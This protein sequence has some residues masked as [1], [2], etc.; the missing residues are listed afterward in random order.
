VTTSQTARV[1]NIEKI[2]ITDALDGDDVDLSLFGATGL[3]L[4][5]TDNTAEVTYSAGTGT[6]ELGTTDQEESTF[7]V[8]GNLA[9]SSDVLNITMGSSS[10]AGTGYGLLNVNNF[11]TVNVQFLVGALSAGEAN[12]GITMSPSI[13]STVNVTGSFGSAMGVIT[14]STINASALSLTGV[15]ATGVTLTAGIGSYVTGSMGVDALTGSTSADRLVGG[16][17]ADTLTTAGGSDTLEPG[18]GRD[19]MVMSDVA[20]AASITV[21]TTAAGSYVGAAGSLTNADDL[22]MDCDNAVGE[23]TYVATISTGVA[24]TTVA[25]GTTLSVGTTAVTANGFYV[26]TGTAGDTVAE[27]TGDF[28]IYQD[29]NGNGLIESGEF[30]ITIDNDSGI[31]SPITIVGGTLVITHLI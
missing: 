7:T 24:A 25:I 30:A 21:I 1:T 15:T 14:A 31:T 11:E 13:G 8:N 3:V 17:G 22:N 5:T 27:V 10:T 20:A 12:D 16:S 18:L 29:T 9:S 4:T 26:L 19:A 28:S 2:R 6:L 23:V